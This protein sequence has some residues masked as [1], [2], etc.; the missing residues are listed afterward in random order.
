[1]Y[2]Y[3]DDAIK[4]FHVPKEIFKLISRKELVCIDKV[5][6]ECT[7]IYSH[8]VSLYFHNDELATITDN[9]VVQKVFMNLDDAVKC[10]FTP[11]NL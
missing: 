8:N 5:S 7:K 10:L 6:Y 11:T 4:E 9:S 3:F 1:M 2:F